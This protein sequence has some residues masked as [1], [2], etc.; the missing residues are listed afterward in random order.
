MSLKPHREKFYNDLVREIFFT[1][2]Q[3]WKVW[4]RQTLCPPHHCE[5]ENWCDFYW[6]TTIPQEGIRPHIQRLIELG[7]LVPC[8][9]TWNTPLLP[10]KIQALMFI[11]STRLNKSK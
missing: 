9:A 1:P 11:S 4:E 8:Q 3:S 7:V 6:G 10:V 2:G 5:A